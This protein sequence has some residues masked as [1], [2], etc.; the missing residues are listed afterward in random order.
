MTRSLFVHQVIL[1][2]LNNLYQ[3]KLRIVVIFVNGYGWLVIHI[4]KESHAEARR[5][6][7][8]ECLNFNSNII[9]VK[10]HSMKLKILGVLGALGGSFLKILCIFIQ[11]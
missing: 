4:G 5:H 11:N 9:N 7:E 1:Q 8:Y 6:R 3:F 2:R 10:L